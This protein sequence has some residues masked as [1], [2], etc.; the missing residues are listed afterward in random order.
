MGWKFK[1]VSSTNENSNVYHP[2]KCNPMRDRA[3]HLFVGDGEFRMNIF[4]SKL[5]THYPLALKVI[6]R[7]QVIWEEKDLC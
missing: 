3:C 5:A 4:P 7:E 6:K 2:A 1:N